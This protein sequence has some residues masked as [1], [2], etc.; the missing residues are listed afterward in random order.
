MNRLFE[1]RILGNFAEI[2]K[3]RLRPSEYVRYKGKGVRY[4]LGRLT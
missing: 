1:K 2:E 4:I 3:A